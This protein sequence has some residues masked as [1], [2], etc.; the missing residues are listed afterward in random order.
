MAGTVLT[1]ITIPKNTTTPTRFRSSAIT[2]LASDTYHPYFPQT[3]IDQNIVMYTSRIV[4]NQFG[5]TK[6]RIQL[7]LVG[8]EGLGNSNGAY[9]APLYYTPNA[10][11]TAAAGYTSIFRK[12]AALFNTVPANGW[13]LEVCH[14][15]NVSG[16]SY[17]SLFNKTKDLQVTATELTT[18][19]TTPTVQS[20]AFD[21]SVAN[22][23]EGDSFELRDKNGGGSYIYRACVYITINPIVQTALYKRIAKY[24]TAATLNFSRAVAHFAKDYEVAAKDTE[25]TGTV[26]L[27]DAGAADSGTTSTA[28]SGSSLTGFASTAA[29]KQ[30]GSLVC[31]SGSRFIAKNAANVDYVNEVRVIET[32]VPVDA[33]TL[34][35]LGML[36]GR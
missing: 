3:E 36:M 35:I 17:V 2:T 30:R 12:I 23:D 11:Y 31:P 26:T 6:T 14:S 27:E 7:S 28:V 25:G 15:R 16:T 19:A 32:I 9:L 1:S 20:V 5:A 13:T 29:L 21:A 18:T 22:F 4:V 24:S 10:A 34:A 33:Q 8:W